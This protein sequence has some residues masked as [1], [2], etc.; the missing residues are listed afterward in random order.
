VQLF[1]L[2]HTGIVS[3]TA[4]HMELNE[5]ER[6]AAWNLGFGRGCSAPCAT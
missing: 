4:K 6:H 5:E 3:I 1:V 2:H